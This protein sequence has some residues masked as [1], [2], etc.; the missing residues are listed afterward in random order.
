[1]A[2]KLFGAVS[3]GAVSVGVM[4]LAAVLLFGGCASPK[5]QKADEKQI[6]EQGIN[7]YSGDFRVELTP[8]TG[9]RA[10]AAITNK[11]NTTYTGVVFRLALVTDDGK[12]T[13]TDETGAYSHLYPNETV[14]Y[15][16]EV[17][18]ISKTAAYVYYVDNDRFANSPDINF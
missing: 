5:S 16:V 11:S 17:A 9:G 1:M 3:V 14:H 12:I 18:D 15:Y 6:I 8:W 10:Q 2:K 13:T 4:L 7:A